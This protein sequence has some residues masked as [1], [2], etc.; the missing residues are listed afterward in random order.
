MRDLRPT[1]F[2]FFSFLIFKNPLQRSLGTQ[3]MESKV[4]SA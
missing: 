1:L 2:F 4:S 3:L